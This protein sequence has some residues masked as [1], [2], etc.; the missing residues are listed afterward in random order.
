LA[1][2]LGGTHP[3]RKPVFGALDVERAVVV[4]VPVV[5]RVLVVVPERRAAVSVIVVRHVIFLFDARSAQQAHLDRRCAEAPGRFVDESFDGG[6]MRV[7]PAVLSF[8]AA[9]HTA[10]AAAGAAGYKPRL[11]SSR[12]NASK[13]ARPRERTKPRHARPS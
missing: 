4:A 6:R 7:H 1:A 3:T 13:P 12:S 10:F 11:R 9:A 5:V 2:L 8:S